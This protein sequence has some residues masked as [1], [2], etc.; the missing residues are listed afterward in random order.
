MMILLLYHTRDE[1]LQTEVMFGE[2]L[3]ELKIVQISIFSLL[4]APLAEE[5]ISQ[6]WD[7]YKSEKVSCGD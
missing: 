6:T 1:A 7:A 2:E 5:G 3:P 4:G